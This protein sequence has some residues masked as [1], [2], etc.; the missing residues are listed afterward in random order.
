MSDQCNASGCNIVSDEDK[1][2]T[3]GKQPLKTEF[4]PAYHGGFSVGCGQ[5]Y[6][7]GRLGTILA[8]NSVSPCFPGQSFQEDL[9]EY[10][11]AGVLGLSSSTMT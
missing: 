3:L 2:N 7:D 11:L 6:E 1:F 9:Q 10:I 4:F 5:L 8:A